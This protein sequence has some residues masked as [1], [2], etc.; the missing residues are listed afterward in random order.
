MHTRATVKN[1]LKRSQRGNT[2]EGL[3]RD[4]QARVLVSVL[5]GAVSGI[6][7]AALAFLGVLARRSESDVLRL[8]STPAAVFIGSVLASASVGLLSRWATNRLSKVG[9]G[10]V[11]GV[12]LV[13]VAAIPERGWPWSWSAELS[14]A[15]VAAGAAGGAVIAALLLIRE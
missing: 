15:V 12:I 9:L 7:L 1:A 13:A 14:G 11:A 2:D 5:G 6:L 10:A 8:A 4:L 3:A